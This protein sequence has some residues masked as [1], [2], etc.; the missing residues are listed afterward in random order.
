M[1]DHPNEVYYKRLFNNASH[2]VIKLFDKAKLTEH[3]FVL[4]IAVLI[5]L[6]GGYGAVVIQYSIKMFQHMFWRGDFTLETVKAIPWYWKLIIPLM[7]GIVVGLVIRFVAKE[8][9][10]HGVPEVMEAI[11][12]RNGILPPFVQGTFLWPK[13]SS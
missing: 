3:T 12:L 10:G 6:L 9:K 4:I 7:G 5:G 11:A 2:Y 1:P 8:A 13:A